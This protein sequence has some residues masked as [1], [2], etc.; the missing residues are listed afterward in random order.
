MNS[1]TTNGSV[2]LLV[3][4]SIEQF[5]Y[6]ELKERMSIYSDQYKAYIYNHLSTNKEKC[7]F[8]SVCL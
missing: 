5:K 8:E 1:S 3:R 7:I 2:L 6:A 4:S